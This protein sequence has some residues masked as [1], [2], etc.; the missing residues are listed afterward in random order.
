VERDSD[1]QMIFSDVKVI[2]RL[3]YEKSGLK[4]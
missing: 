2:Q 4:L 1:L 3:K